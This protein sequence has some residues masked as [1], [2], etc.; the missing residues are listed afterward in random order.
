MYNKNIKNWTVIFK[1]NNKAINYE[2]IHLLKL[3]LIHILIREIPSKT[4]VTSISII[5][6]LNLILGLSRYL[7]M[8]Y[9]S[10]IIAES[11]QL[12]III[13]LNFNFEFK[14]IWLFNISELVN[15]LLISFIPSIF[16]YC[17]SCQS[18]ITK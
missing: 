13:L 9:G 4:I 1:K 16:L 8:N 14:I 12:P 6:L 15:I 5:I 3:I 10:G 18:S 2:K 11:E 7:M 17:L